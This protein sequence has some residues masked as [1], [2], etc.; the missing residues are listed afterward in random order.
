MVDSAIEKVQLATISFLQSAED[1]ALGAAGSVLM[2]FVNA[3][4]PF[5]PEGDGFADEDTEAKDPAKK[6]PAVMRKEAD[7][8]NKQLREG[9]FL[10]TLHL[11]MEYAG[12]FANLSDKIRRMRGRLQDLKLA[13]EAKVP[14]LDNMSKK[15]ILTGKKDFL[16]KYAPPKMQRQKDQ[17][18]KKT[19]MEGFFMEI[20]KGKTEVGKIGKDISKLENEL[21]SRKD[22]YPEAKTAVQGLVEGGADINSV[23]EDGFTALML[24]ARNGH[25]ETVEALL[26]VPKIDT[27]KKNSYGSN[28][29]HYA[30]MYAHRDVVQFL[31]RKGKIKKGEK[32]ASGKTP[33]ELALDEAKDL[34][35]HKTEIWTNSTYKGGM[36]KLVTDLGK[37]DVPDDPIYNAMGIHAPDQVDPPKVWQPN[38]WRIS[39]IPDPGCKL[40]D[41][42]EK[43]FLKRWNRAA[44]KC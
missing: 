34:L 10:G 33:K 35:Q 39:K 8:R 25:L 4:A 22:E 42:D 44:K 43:T 14:G 16:A 20:L 7:N 15:E 1:I 37:K 29:M 38:F 40:D 28:A 5:V 11:P 41:M 32:N 18:L 19:L 6:K 21:A 23:N 2:P 12:A 31:R 3:P 26:E 9:A 30:A 27:N 13:L 24:A 17:E 36:Y